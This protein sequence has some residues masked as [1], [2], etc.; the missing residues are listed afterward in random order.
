MRGRTEGCRGQGNQDKRNDLEMKQRRRKD[1]RFAKVD[2][3]Y[4]DS[5]GYLTI[6]AGPLRG[7]RVH[8]LVALAKYGAHAVQKRDVVIHHIDGDKENPHPDNLELMTEREHNSVSAKQY[9]YLKKH[10][11]P[12][13][14]AQFDAYFAETNSSIQETA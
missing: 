3:T 11:W 14:K 4:V 9:W 5:R 13:E 8:R 1:G 10:V 12:V 7:M 2:G 6:C